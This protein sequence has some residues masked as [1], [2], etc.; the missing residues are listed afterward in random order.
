[1]QVNNVTKTEEGVFSFDGNMSQTEHDLVV[2]MGL[3]FLLS[4]GLLDTLV[5][6]VQTTQIDE[7]MP[8]Q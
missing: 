4:Q 5:P 7:S 8:K 2:T 1:M 3:N 6:S